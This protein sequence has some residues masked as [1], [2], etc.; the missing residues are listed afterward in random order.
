MRDFV[1]ALLRQEGALVEEIDP[2]GL[3]VLAP[4]PV[5]LAL[6]VGELSRLGFGATLP[7][8]GQRVSLEGDWLARFD[9]VLGIHGRW[10][11][12][13][14]PM[15]VRT[16]DDPE[17]MLDHALVLDN[18][19]FRLIGAAPAWTRY[20]LL[21]FRVSAV[22][23][24][25]RDFMVRLGINLATGAVPDAVIAALTPSLE[26]SLGDWERCD[27]MPTDGAEPP[28]MWERGRVLDLVA[29]A[30]PP[31]LDTAL[32]PFV[33]GLRRRHARD[34]A[35]LHLYHN[36][37]HHEAMRRALAFPDGD[38]R[39]HREEQRS[40]AI[41]RE[42][43]AKLDDL[44]RQYATRVTVEWIQ[45]LELTMPVH[46]FT[47][48]VRRRK[49]DRTLRLDWNPLARRLELPLCEATAAVERPRLVCDDALHLVVPAALG[50]CAR[51]GRAYCR[52]CHPGHCPKCGGGMSVSKQARHGAFEKG[53][54]DRSHIHKDQAFG[55]P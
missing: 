17:R 32:E 16:P 20:L 18:A 23:D 14:L 12:R 29:R 34:Q 22:S 6:G 31:R 42:Y 19:T 45:T 9:R 46:R 33:R 27:P 8:G 47:V 50:P 53:L 35:R 43:R 38:P 55:R 25:K 3:E 7:P 54:L 4:P 37:L 21:D 44:A 52:A 39:R 10:T 13:V 49:A 2:E 30:L 1:A 26:Q 51:C 48:Q 24:D 40:E 41:G 28:A 5:R 15:A 36:D 11:R